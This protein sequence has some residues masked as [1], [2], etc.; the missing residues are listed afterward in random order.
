MGK[1]G[2]VWDRE[3]EEGIMVIRGKGMGSEEKGREGRKEGGKR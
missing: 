3:G 2:V 1:K